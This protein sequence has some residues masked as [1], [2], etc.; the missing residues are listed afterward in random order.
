ML[1]FA[2][3][4]G[5][6]TDNCENR[7]PSSILASKMR[8]ESGQNKSE[9]LSETGLDIWSRLLDQCRCERKKKSDICEEKNSLQ[10]SEDTKE[11][12]PESL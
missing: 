5:A 12:F 10:E 11:S 4:Y 7:D 8:L 3:T 2:D 9:V 1:I 6:Q